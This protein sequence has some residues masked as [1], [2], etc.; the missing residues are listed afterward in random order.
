MGGEKGCVGRVDGQVVSRNAFKARLT[1]L[2][3]LRAIWMIMYRLKQERAQKRFRAALCDGRF[4]A[5]FDK[6]TGLRPEPRIAAAECARKHLFVL[7][8]A[9]IRTHARGRSITDSW[10][11]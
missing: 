7:S 4:W 11:A 1:A 8:R 2:E 5:V 10:Y 6:K 3:S 9:R